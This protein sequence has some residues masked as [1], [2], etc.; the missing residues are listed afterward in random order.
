MQEILRY[1]PKWLKSALQRLAFWVGH[2]CTIYSDWALTEGALVAELCNLIHAHL[3]D[4]YSLHCE[5]PYKKFVKQNKYAQIGD[6]ARVDLSVW[7][8]IQEPEGK[9]KIPRFAIE[10]KRAKSASSLIN[11]DLVR[12]AEIAEHNSRI[13]AFL[14]VV[15]ERHL[16]TQF[17]T[18]RG[19]RRGG[20]FPIEGTSSSYQ[21]ISVLKATAFLK[22]V[23]LDRAH[24]CCT[25]EVL[26]NEF[27]EEE[28]QE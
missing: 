16:P 10:V 4:K 18:P 6:G 22:E 8:T 28:L 19:Y 20:I 9:R 25:I 21:V 7:E 26:S 23:N 1:S 3:G 12:L 2:R 5:E 11:R 27:I 15:S 17:V 14:C 24:Y 13:R